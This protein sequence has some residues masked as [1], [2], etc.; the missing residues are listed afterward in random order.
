M[1][2][3]EGSV[4]E[5]AERGQFALAIVR[6]Q[7]GRKRILVLR[8]DGRTQNISARQ[9]TALLPHPLDTALPRDTLTDTL[10]HL[11]SDAARLA[12]R[13]DL[14]TLWELLNETRPGDELPLATLS[15]LL[16]HADTN[17][18][19]LATLLALRED[20][21]RFKARKLAFQARSPEQVE[22]IQHAQRVAE[23][24]EAR[25]ERFLDHIVAALTTPQP[26]Q[27]ESELQP[28]LDA[29][30]A[31]AVA[32]DD[33]STRDEADPLI[34]T[35]AE[36]ADIHFE[37]R[38]S[39]RAFALLVRLDIFAPDEDLAMRR[40]DIPDAFSSTQRKHALALYDT[41]LE[42][43]HRVDLTHL[44][45][46]TIDDAETPD[47]DDALS[48]EVLHD[49]GLVRVGVHI[50][51]PNHFIPL[52]SPLE[53]EAMRRGS[54]LYLPTGRVPML[55]VELSE[56]LASLVSGH[57]RP[58]LSF[59]IDFDPFHEIQ[60]FQILPSFIKV[61]SN[62][63]YPDAENLLVRGE[64]SLAEALRELYEISSIL[65]STRL[66][67]G[68]IHLALPEVKIH[69]SPEGDFKV[70]TIDQ[71]SMARELVSELMI[72]TNTLAARFFNDNT[73]PAFYRYQP[74]PERPLDSPELLAVPEGLPRAFAR[75]RRMRP[76]DTSLT[77]SLH[78]ALA[79]EAYTQITSPLRRYPDLLLHYQ[80]HS[81]LTQGHPALSRD[82]FSDRLTRGEA[83]AGDARQANSESIQYWLLR[84][85]ETL[86]GQHVT[87]T[88]IDH[89]AGNTS[90]VVLDTTQL[91]ARVT[92]RPLPEIGETVEL[93]VESVHPRTQHILLAPTR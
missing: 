10:Q 20:T 79:V 88:V 89:G 61:H 87:A 76:A 74:S 28:L 49:E 11:R 2:Y 54:T 24:K 57:I 16:F 29:I 7:E 50:A 53:L 60:R 35:L 55:P 68:A 48:L 85:L 6:R 22:S 71:R 34:D 92:L 73:I 78:A 1:R 75:R 38:G 67:A 26:L 83:A 69:V 62:L 19:A 52:D 39:N 15:E 82:A 42:D 86:Q 13:A 41:P 93:L 14:D 37:E 23:L 3:P 46:C 65:L 33:A 17:L 44:L 43:P 56:D 58:A 36:R 77:P 40:Y 64:G 66:A 31:Y 51:S 80:M 4:V 25:R 63:S 45:T 70:H 27:L 8:E 91:R 59:L 21:L 12:Q 47:Y 84:Y 30:I 90:H 32:G 5:L 81:F 18:H 9:L 72:T